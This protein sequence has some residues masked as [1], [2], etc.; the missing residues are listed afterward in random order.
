[1]PEVSGKLPFVGDTKKCTYGFE[2][3][4]ILYK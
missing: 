2:K 3:I 1:M 4:R